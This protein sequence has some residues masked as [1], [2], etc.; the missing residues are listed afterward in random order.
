M[1]YDRMLRNLALLRENGARTQNGFPFE[2]VSGYPKEGDLGGGEVI[3]PAE[4]VPEGRLRLLWWGAPHPQP[5][6]GRNY[7]HGGGAKGPTAKEN[8]FEAMTY[9]CPEGTVAMTFPDKYSISLWQPRTWDENSEKTLICCRMRTRGYVPMTSSRGRRFTIP[10]ANEGNTMIAL[11][12][13]PIHLEFLTWTGQYLD[14]SATMRKILESFEEQDY[15]VAL[16]VYDCSLEIELLLV[17]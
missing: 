1:A 12:E 5:S 3:N 10:E 16:G 11:Q 9:L 13:A 4:L 6:S 15:A 17:D 8:A 14:F 2:K 7:R